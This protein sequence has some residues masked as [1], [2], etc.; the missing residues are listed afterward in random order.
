MSGDGY[1]REDDDFVREVSCDDFAGIE[2]EKYNDGF[3]RRRCPVIVKQG[4]RR[5][6]CPAMVLR[7]R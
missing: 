7:G 5:R 6:R 3:V 1:A 2:K 4:K